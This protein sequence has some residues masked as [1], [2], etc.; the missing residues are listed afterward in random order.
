M[1]RVDLTAA[2]RR[3]TDEMTYSAYLVVANTLTKSPP[4]STSLP[5]LR[6]AVLRNFTVEPLI[7]VIQGEIARAG[8]YPEIYLGAYD[9]MM[10]DVLDPDSALYAFQPDSSVL[11]GLG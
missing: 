7:P 10:Q 2:L 11:K 3:L 9:A 8:F 5:R 6:V 4:E 1:D